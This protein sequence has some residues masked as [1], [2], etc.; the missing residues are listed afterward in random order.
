MHVCLGD[1]HSADKNVKK[2][3]RKGSVIDDRK[4][5]TSY[6]NDVASGSGK[7]NSNSDSD[8]DDRHD[9]YEQYEQDRD[10]LVEFSENYAKS[11]FK[12]G[13]NRKRKGTK[14]YVQ[15]IYLAH[16]DVVDSC[17]RSDSGS[18]IM[19]FLVIL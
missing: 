14:I 15:E 7:N 9:D 11:D 13:Q 3:S 16:C 1:V 2:P 10:E 6:D 5:G 19:C 8:D 4:A 17:M 18:L 12:I